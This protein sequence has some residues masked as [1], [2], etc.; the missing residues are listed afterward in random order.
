MTI[1]HPIESWPPGSSPFSRDFNDLINLYG[2]L[3]TWVQSN[4]SDI[5]DLLVRPE[6]P[7]PP[8]PEGPFYALITDSGTPFAP[9]RFDYS[10][11]EVRFDAETR[12][13]GVF[14]GS[15]SSAS[16]GETTALNLAEFTNTDMVAAHGVVLDTLEALGTVQQ[17]PI[18]TPVTLTLAGS[19]DVGGTFTNFRVFSEV[20]AINFGC[21]PLAAEFE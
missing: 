21:V 19:L 9:N 1:L 13:F 3:L 8:I 4:Q 16:S 18:G 6:W 7:D 10:W 20:N 14:T 17:I 11:D 15:R 12:T 2:E 5:E